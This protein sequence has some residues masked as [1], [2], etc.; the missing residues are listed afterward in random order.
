MGS[1]ANMLFPDFGSGNFRK[2]SLANQI[3]LFVY[4]KIKYQKYK[5]VI[6]LIRA[7][8]NWYCDYCDRYCDCDII[9]DYNVWINFTSQFSLSLKKLLKSWWC[10]VSASLCQTNMFITSGEKRVV[11]QII[12]AAL[13]RFIKTLFCATFYLYKIIVVL[14]IWLLHWVMMRFGLRC[15]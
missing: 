13:R 1:F 14:T 11:G 5:S 12:S 15:D 4:L 7:A 2:L 9:H 3:T 6:L 10:G 8:R